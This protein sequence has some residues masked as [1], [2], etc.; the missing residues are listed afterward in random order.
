MVTTT[1]LI[2]L[3]VLGAVACLYVFRD[4]LFAKKE[5]T[6]S[7]LN[8]AALNGGETET[9]WL[10]KL[11]KQVSISDHREQAS[12]RERV[13]SWSKMRSEKIRRWGERLD[14]PRHG[15]ISSLCL[16]LKR[17]LHT[18]LSHSIILER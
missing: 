14:L 2:I 4:S 6:L 17:L 9:D 7:K 11:K 18:Q 3:A 1:D 10:E 5:D 8:G 16:E 12:E 13:V 15:L